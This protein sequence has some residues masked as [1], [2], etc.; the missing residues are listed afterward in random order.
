[1]AEHQSWIERRQRMVRCKTHGLHFDPRLSSGCVL[2]VKEWAKLLPNGASPRYLSAGYVVYSEKGSLRLAR[3]NLED[4]QL[5]RAAVPV[6][7]G[8][9]WKNRAVAE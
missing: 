3:F 8:V 4:G 9:Q 7:D 6:L 1:M 5:D 2:C